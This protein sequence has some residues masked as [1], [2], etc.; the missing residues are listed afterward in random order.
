MDVR[1]VRLAW[2]SEVPEGTG[3]TLYPISKRVDDEALLYVWFLQRLFLNQAS[4]SNVG[5]PFL[6]FKHESR[7]ARNPD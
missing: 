4:Y 3:N 7:L 6:H 2:R 5:M 1:E